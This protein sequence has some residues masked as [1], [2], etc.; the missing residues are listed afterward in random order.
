MQPS[1]DRLQHVRWRSYKCVDFEI[2]FKMN[3][4]G[5]E[6]KKK[7]KMN[8]LRRQSSFASFD[9]VKIDQ[10]IPGPFNKRMNFA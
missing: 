7:K 6:I 10:S 8:S 4:K 3:L 9:T 1:K 2:R 5:L